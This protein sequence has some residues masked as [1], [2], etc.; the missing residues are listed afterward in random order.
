MNRQ[1]ELWSS[2]HADMLIMAESLVF[3]R[4]KWMVVYALPIYRSFSNK[5]QIL[6]YIGHEMIHCTSSL[7]DLIFFLFN[8]HHCR[9]FFHL[10]STFLFTTM[11][12]TWG[13]FFTVMWIIISY[14]YYQLTTNSLHLK[15]SPN[16]KSLPR[17]KRIGTVCS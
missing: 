3:L 6:F 8:I 7:S 11:T 4:L 16:R 12:G 2:F 5:H 13:F 1:N 14:I 9:H 15:H 10:F 17:T